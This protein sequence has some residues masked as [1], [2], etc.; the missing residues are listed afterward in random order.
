MGR[1]VGPVVPL[2]LAEARLAAAGSEPVLVRAVGADDGRRAGLLT[3]HTAERKGT[4]VW[5]VH[6][7]HRVVF[8][9]DT[10]PSMRTLRGGSDA[11]RTPLAAVG[12]ALADCFQGL[13]RPM[14]ALRHKVHVSVVAHVHT[15]EAA[16]AAPRGHGR[17]GRGQDS[18]VGL[19]QGFL[20]TG[21]DRDS[22][23][24]CAEEL[25]A[26]A[27]EALG[28][29][30]DS[31]WG[32]IAANPRQA[33]RTASALGGAGHRRRAPRG[34]EAGGGGGGGVAVV[35]PPSSL[36]PMIEAGV[37]ALKW[38]PPDAVP[39]IVLVTDGVCRDKQLL[40]TYDGMIMQLCRRD[41]T[42]HVLQVTQ[43][44]IESLQTLGGVLPA[45]LCLPPL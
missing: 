9:V 22:S 10:S 6:E 11:A 18:V 17:G 27:A 41:V 24:A 4:E 5:F 30:E 13:A 1:L 43:R 23:W 32:I 28:R 14:G 38:L 34:G 20:L 35:A 2:P 42:L 36:E 7:R 29:L 15:Q 25:A 16:A 45:R 21:V 19:V 26:A 40:T 33:P 37:F 31:L 39:A 12:L 3:P 8:V 44:Q